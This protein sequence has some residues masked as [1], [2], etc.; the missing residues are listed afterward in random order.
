MKITTILLFLNILNSMGYSLIAPLFPILGKQNGL[1]DAIIGWIISTYAITN[2]IVTP[3]IPSLVLKFTRLK[4]LYLSTF[5]VATCTILYSFLYYISSFYLLIIS[6]IIIRII[7]GFSSSI[8]FTLAYSL[9]IS[10]SEKEYLQK[11]LGYLELGLC[12]GISCGPLIASIFYKIGGYP[13][14]FL[15]LGIFLYISVYLTSKIGKEK[16]NSKETE[17]KKSIRFIKFFYISEILIIL[18]SFFTTMIAATFYL[19]SLTNY[20]IQ[21]YNFS[22]SIASLFFIVPTIFYVAIL[23][24]LDLLS[25][26]FGLYGTACLGLFMMSLGSFLLAPLINIFN[27]IVLFIFGFGILGGGQAPVFI[28]L[29]IALS[30]CIIKNEKNIDELTAN[31]IATAINNLSIAIGEFSGPIIGGYLTSNFGFNYCSFIISIFIFAYLC[32]FS[33]YFSNE[34]GSKINDK[35]ELLEKDKNGN[36]ILNIKSIRNYFSNYKKAF[37]LE[38]NNRNENKKRN[39]MNILENIDKLDKISLYS[40]LTK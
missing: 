22:V 32:I 39:T 10:L 29:L 4:L 2:A 15:V 38:S 1:N 21:R 20:I 33:C 28:P 25:K 8:V 35:E 13:L 23:Q 6:A 27:N 14:P 5:L 40:S 26:F 24:L 31:D 18:G 16:I 7:N 3:F 36:T 17:E 30:K 12:L 34:I 9:T 37:L 11:S 19:P